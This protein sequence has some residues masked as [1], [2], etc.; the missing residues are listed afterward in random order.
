MLLSFLIDQT[1]ARRSVLRGRK[2]VTR[3]YQ[4]GLPLPGWVLI[5][6]TGILNIIIGGIIYVVM[7][8]VVLSSSNQTHSN[9]YTPGLLSEP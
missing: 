5:V 4:R 1:E 2:T 9:S 6:I 3:H 7:R 8:K